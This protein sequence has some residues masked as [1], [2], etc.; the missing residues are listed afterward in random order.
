MC[1]RF[2]D[3]V[4]VFDGMEGGRATSRRGT[5]CLP[6]SL[7]RARCAAQ[8]VHAARL[9][10]TATEGFILPKGEAVHTLSHKRRLEMDL[11]KCGQH[12]R[13]ELIFFFTF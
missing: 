5:P 1:G 6:A 13:F 9:L 2:S 7:S 3:T 4:R 12:A 11:S 10:A 8:Q